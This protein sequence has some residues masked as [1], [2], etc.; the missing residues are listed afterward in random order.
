M[1][2]FYNFL[3][4]IVRFFFNINAK[5]PVKP[6]KTIIDYDIVAVVVPLN[7][8]GGVI[9]GIFN[10]IFPNIIIEILLFCFLAYV[11]YKMIVK[12]IETFK[13]ET[14]KFEADKLALTMMVGKEAHEK[15]IDDLPVDEKMELHK[16]LIHSATVR[17]NEAEAWNDMVQPKGA[18]E[19]YVRRLSKH[20]SKH[21]YQNLDKTD[22]EFR[23]MSDFSSDSK[24][25]DLSDRS[26]R[27]QSVKSVVDLQHP[28]GYSIN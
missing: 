28:V 19:N 21:V 17:I 9:G 8:L 23:R 18:P 2:S 16:T 10:A 13:K 24:Q 22:D 3:S 5:N 26:K 15:E 27:S 11:G 6:N 1:N 14:K 7:I 25:S 12:G 20:K 4:A